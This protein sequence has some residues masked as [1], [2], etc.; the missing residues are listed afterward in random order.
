MDV[1]EMVDYINKRSSCIDIIET[2]KNSFENFYKDKIN[3]EFIIEYEY[4]PVVI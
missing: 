4:G 1:D 2:I 3:Y